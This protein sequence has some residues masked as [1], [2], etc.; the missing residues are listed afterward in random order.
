MASEAER[1]IVP[2]TSRKG[3]E[4]IL[5]IAARLDPGRFA[6]VFS[7]KG[8]EA[9]VSA[10]RER[11]WTVIWPG[12]LEDPLHFAVFG[13]GDVYLLLSR[14]E[15]APLPLLET[16][17]LGLWPVATP[18]GIAPEILSDGDNGHLLPAFDGGNVAAVAEAVASHLRE[19]DREALQA[20]R[21]RVRRSVAHRTWPRFRAQIEAILDKVCDSPVG[22]EGPPPA[23]LEGKERA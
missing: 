5:P 22:L 23:P 16:M 21:E 7:G 8:W 19:L 12:S 10:L 11:G 4:L 14:L 13:E 18:V 17:G 20:R 6:W 15:G 9:H 2:E 3:E 1:R